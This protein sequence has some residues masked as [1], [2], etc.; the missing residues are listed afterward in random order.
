MSATTTFG[1]DVLTSI[2][3][4]GIN[5]SAFL[6]VYRHRQYRYHLNRFTAQ[7]DLYIWDRQHTKS[8]LTK[9]FWTTS[10]QMPR[11][12]E[13]R[14]GGEKFLDVNRTSELPQAASLRDIRDETQ[15]LES[16]WNLFN[17]KLSMNQAGGGVFPAWP[18]RLATENFQSPTDDQIFASL[19]FLR[20][21]SGGRKLDYKNES[22]KKKENQ[23]SFVWVS[24]WSAKLI[25]ISSR[26]LKARSV[27]SS[28]KFNNLKT[29]KSLR[30]IKQS[31]GR[32]RWVTRNLILV[33]RKQERPAHLSA[34]QSGL[35]GRQRRKW[36][37]IKLTN[38]KK[39]ER[40]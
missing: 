19:R 14:I 1:G 9:E 5:D 2:K 17:R 36:K 8:D 24:L 32:K 10:W 31:N 18:R 28:N 26:C 16:R 27:G 3:L 39:V 37:M 30:L 34:I 38:D 40:D 20:K 6:L 7:L 33:I 4:V 23:K 21:Q 15:R 11:L 22:L 35:P 13:G 25:T 29:Q 12:H